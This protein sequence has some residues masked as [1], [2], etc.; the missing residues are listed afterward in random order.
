MGNMQVLDQ[1]SP[2]AVTKVT[3]DFLSQLGAGETLTLATVSV[4]VWTGVD[5]S[6]AA[7]LDG[8]PSLSGSQ[9]SQLIQDGIAGVVYK[10]R[11]QASTSLG[12]IVVMYSY[13][14]VVE[15]PL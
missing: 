1:K 10:I 3:W 13:L 8:A 7:I 6:P 14:A 15:D 5:P 2:E 4:S 12:Q 9:V 11:V